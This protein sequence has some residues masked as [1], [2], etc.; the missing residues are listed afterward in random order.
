MS[1][2]LYF[3]VGSEERSPRRRRFDTLSQNRAVDA[4]LS[5]GGIQ[6]NTIKLFFLAARNTAEER[7]YLLIGDILPRSPVCRGRARRLNGR[8]KVNVFPR[9]GDTVRPRSEV[10]Q[11]RKPAPIQ[12]GRTM[13]EDGDRV[14]TMPPTSVTLRH[15]LLLSPSYLCSRFSSVPAPKSIGAVLNG[16]L[17]INWERN[18]KKYQ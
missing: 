14:P 18:D 12:P 1:N 13:D 10:Y 16:R 8:A 17:E 4:T 3:W 11:K 5:S 6:R 15:S 9:G 7:D 2:K